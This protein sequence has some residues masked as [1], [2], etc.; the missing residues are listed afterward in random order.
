MYIIM[1]SLLFNHLEGKPLFSVSG[2]MTTLV[3]S[4]DD[5]IKWKHFLRYWPFVRG[6]H[7]SPVNSPHKG[8]WRRALIFSLICALNKQW[9]KQSWDW[10]F[11]IQLRSFWRH[12]NELLICASSLLYVA[13]H[14]ANKMGE[15]GTLYSTRRPVYTKGHMVYIRVNS[16]C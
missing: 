6:I 14:L 15:Q 13:S 11:E 1:I 12:C 5:V 10:W 3:V 4:H 16:G 7:R 2:N 8:R 9:S